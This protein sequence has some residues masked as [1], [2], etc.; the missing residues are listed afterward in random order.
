MWQSTM[1]QVGVGGNFNLTPLTIIHSEFQYGAHQCN[2]NIS[3]Y[4]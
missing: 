3:N 4:F 1:L 2:V